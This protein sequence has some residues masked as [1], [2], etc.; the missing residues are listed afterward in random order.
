M[1]ATGIRH[2]LI[3]KHQP[4]ALL[5]W[6]IA[7]EAGSL[8][9]SMALAHRH[10]FALSVSEDCPRAA[11]LYKMVANLTASPSSTTL[12]ILLPSLLMPSPRRR[13]RD[14][15]SSPP[16][17]EFVQYFERAASRGDPIA[18]VEL[19]KLIY[20]RHDASERD[21]VRATTLFKNAARA[22]RLDAHALLGFIH[23]NAGHNATAI[24]H[25][26]A[27]A[28]RG[29]PNSLHALGFA[30]LHGIGGPKNATAAASFF[31]LAVEQKH[32]D[33]FYNLA[34]MYDEGI[35][36]PKSPL[37][38][39]SCLTA[40]ATLDH[41]QASHQLAL[42][43]LAGEPPVE[44]NCMEAVSLLKK[45]AES[46][47]WHDYID[48]AG[49]L[50]E[51]GLY[52]QALYRYLKA[53]HAGLEVA[54]YNAGFMYEKGTVLDRG[55]SATSLSRPELVRNAIEM[56]SMSA[57]QG[58][59]PSMIRIGDLAFAEMRDYPR[60]AAA[61]DK[62]A[63]RESAE[64]HFNLG[65][66]HARGYGMNADKHIAK[67]YF[68][69]AK[70]IDT[71]AWLPST[72]AIFGLK[73]YEIVFGGLA[74]LSSIYDE[75][76]RYISDILTVTVLLGVLVLVVNARQRRLL[77]LHRDEGIEGDVQ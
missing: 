17:D 77:R 61:Y 41:I 42:R 43:Y 24:Q 23:L 59:V 65:W 7:A 69:N 62:A 64:A 8:Y 20:F 25:F 39:V 45:V 50:H 73:H 53:A 63:R 6:T 60:A 12:R 26:T 1:Y 30:S 2:Y 68:D 67:R 13:L 56:Y 47:V 52:A 54:Q 11:Q 28:N 75:Y 35:G 32:P 55:F 46:G 31:K 3:P 27:A 44:Y 38:A 37:K 36:V 14:Q 4:P 48:T 15:N 49:R 72:I 51:K 21:V 29:E 16:S 10:H 9:A 33:A 58:D 70:A 66:M 18:Q 57:A 71:D 22:G 40:A 19:A 76:S 5:H 74:L 34:Y